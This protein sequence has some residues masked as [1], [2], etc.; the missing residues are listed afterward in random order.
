MTLKKP[1]F[2]VFLILILGNTGFVFSQ[3]TDTIPPQ[4]IN[5]VTDTLIYCSE[6]IPVA[7]DISIQSISID[8]P[9]EGMKI[10]IANYQKGED[11]LLYNG[12]KFISKWN[13][14]YGHLEIKGVGTAEEY[15]QAIA[16]VYYKNLAPVP[17]LGTRSFSISL[18]DADYLPSTQHFYRYI[19]ALDI[20]WTEA[21]DSAAN[22]NY[23]GLQGYLATIRS[24]VENDFIWTKIDGVGW[25][26]ATDEETEGT[27]K[28]VTGP[29]SAIVFWQGDYNGNRVN[30]EYS[31]WNS[32]EPN[33]SPKANGEDEDYAHI[34]N[35]P[36]TIAKS[37]N[38]LSNTGDGP[39][40]QY[41]RAQG[42][43]VEFG[44]MT[45]D[46]EVKLSASAVIDVSKIAFSD[47]RE[48][49]ICQGESQEL[50]VAA[51]NSYNYSWSPDKDITSTTISNPVVYPTE[52]NTY[53]AIGKLDYCT[54]TASFIVNVNPIPV[55]SWEW[56]NYICKGDSITLD[57]GEYELYLWGN[58]ATTR[59]I[60]VADEG[61]YVVKLTNNYGCSSTDTT[62][63]IWSIR[64]EL[65]YGKLQ[66]LV[67][68]SKEQTLNLSFTSGSASTNLISF[69]S[70]KVT[71]ENATS[72]TPTIR[73]TEFGRYQFLMEITDEYSCQFLDT[74]EIEFHNQPEAKFFMDSVK[75]KGYNLELHSTG[76]TVEEA[77][78][79]WYYNGDVFR[80]E[81]DLDSIVIP[82]GYGET[83]RTVGLKVNEQ[84]CIDSSF[85]GVTVIPAMDFWVA[86][87]PEGCTP[88][89]V[90]FGN[91]DVEE[92]E[93]Y[94]WDFGDGNH[95]EIKNPSNTYEN[96]GTT[97]IKF[98][99]R[100][101]VLS[102]EGCENMGVLEEAVVVHPIPTLDISYEEYECNPEQMEIWYTG[103]GNDRDKYYWDLKELLPGEIIRDPGLTKGPLEIKRG[104]EPT[105]E[106]GVYVVSKFGCKSDTT[107][108]K[109]WKRKP[110]FEVKVDKTE[111]CPPLE[112]GIKA[113]VLDNV[114]DV[115]F[116]YSLGDGTSGTGDTIL[117]NYIL[118]DTK[119]EITFIGNSSITGCSD[120]VVFA[121]NVFVYPVPAAG[122][123]PNPETVLI[124]DP[125]IVFENESSGATAYEWDFDDS[126][127]FSTE[128]NPAHRFSGMGFYN[129]RLSAFN[130]YGC[131]D[132]I[133]HQV[134]VAFDKL[135]PPNAFSPNAPNE[136]DR[137]FRIYSEGVSDEGYQLFIFNRWGE[138]IF[139]SQSQHNGWD[140]K[141]RNGN[142]A[143][144]G[145]YTWVLKYYDFRD[146]KHKQQGVVTLLF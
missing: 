39:S 129:V 89:N 68:G 85:Q 120:T 96:T 121:E 25:I 101:T 35:N 140:G 146:E 106:I 132:S 38:D 97:D 42:F 69:Q 104:S 109:T 72:L 64:P 4:I 135:Y 70:D 24:K 122:F 60:T 3:E 5:P 86:E 14:Y 115:S 26:G 130:D 107:F 119:N 65:D 128:E 36:N 92:I 93:S 82:L 88:L 34:N 57:P 136:E 127:F 134:A 144:A 16:N 41:Y 15:E 78:F 80:T 13:D 79:S 98:D 118:P 49:T 133:S 76:Q 94:S 40:S 47:K 17:T 105:V 67:C 32:G 87:N 63:V 27:W 53:T 19:S 90:K 66:T 44:G 126:S 117:H 138:V 28:W 100:L 95:S 131:L 71:V 31:F 29:D 139:E 77:E 145:I 37:W 113:T 45:G 61:F 81:T 30:G 114:D 7:E 11:T 33:N 111:G 54:D 18:L 143:P 52:T 58:G 50:N 22:M 46:P 91:I 12:S 59:T 10:S 108:S 102:T 20:T 56:Q 75:C 74:L 73:V 123:T 9:T 99:V 62:E 110:V 142:F 55:H 1:V 43:I 6:P 83:N 48:F 2:L 84:G 125:E 8:E 112:T 103:S 116:Q 21:R 141:M 51:D 137:E 23:Y 124:S